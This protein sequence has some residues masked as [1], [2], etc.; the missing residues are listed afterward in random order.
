MYCYNKTWSQE[1]YLL[2]SSLLSTQSF[3]LPCSRGEQKQNRSVWARLSQRLHRTA[4]TG[5]KTNE[6]KFERI[7]RKRPSWTNRSAISL[8]VWRDWGQPRNPVRTAGVPTD[9]RTEH[10]LNA[11]LERHRYTNQWVSLFWIVNI[12]RANM[13]LPTKYVTELLVQ[14]SSHWAH[15]T[16]LAQADFHT[17]G[18]LRDDLKPFCQQLSVNWGGAHVVSRPVE[19]SC[20]NGTRKLIQRLKNDEFLGYV[21][22]LS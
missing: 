9:I 5:R 20:C 10:L 6:W 14:V 11:S 2:W 4:S 1:R 19:N 16:D 13:A 15:S 18:H 8:S 12:Q 21:L 7:Q 3:T 17:F 22:L